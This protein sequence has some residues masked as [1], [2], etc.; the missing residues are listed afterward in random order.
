[1][2]KIL[3]STLLIFFSCQILA[4]SNAN[5]GIVASTTNE[6][7]NASLNSKSV[8]K[9]NIF[10][11]LLGYSQFALEKSINDRRGVEFGLGIIGAGKNLNIQPHTFAL[12]LSS[13]PGNY[14]RAGHKNQFGGF[15]EFGYKFKKPFNFNTK[16]QNNFDAANSFDGFYIKPSFIF[17]AYSFNQFRDDSTT[18]T[19]RRHHRFGALLANFG[20]Q[21][22]FDSRIVLDFYFGGGAEIDNVQEGDDLYGHPFVLA[23]AKDNPSVNFAFTAGFRFGFLLK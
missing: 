10:S 13:F 16:S 5:K 21:W 20:Y 22:V 1:M 17:G 2:G 18:V 7:S 19:V 23:V 12:T 14:Y 9:V 15:F 3:F 6:F 4:Q 8:L 11:P